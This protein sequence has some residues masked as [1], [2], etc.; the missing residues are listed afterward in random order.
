M[1]VQLAPPIPPVESLAAFTLLSD[2][3][4]HPTGV[5]CCACGEP[6]DLAD[7]M[8]EAMTHVCRLTHLCADHCPTCH[9]G[10]HRRLKP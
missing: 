1:S 3:E 4:G 5:E 9:P 6:F 10:K 8:V 7:S 2:D